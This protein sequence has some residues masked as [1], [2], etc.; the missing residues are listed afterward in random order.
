MFILVAHAQNLQTNTN[1][2]K[3]RTISVTNTKIPL[4]KLL[5]LVR[6]SCPVTK[7]IPGASGLAQPIPQD[8]MP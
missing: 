3:F 7:H 8:V 2:T 4:Q 1:I 5:A 6:D